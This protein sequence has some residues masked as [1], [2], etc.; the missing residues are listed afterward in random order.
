MASDLSRSEGS[1]AGPQGRRISPDG[2]GGALSTPRLAS[3]QPGSSGPAAPPGGGAQRRKVG[4]AFSLPESSAPGSG[5]EAAPSE[6]SEASLSIRHRKKT[7]RRP[8]SAE[9]GGGGGPAGGGSRGAWVMVPCCFV[10][11]WSGGGA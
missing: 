4:V 11:V 5:L 2:F 6:A 3:T 9:R 8:P 7:P 10:P 1:S